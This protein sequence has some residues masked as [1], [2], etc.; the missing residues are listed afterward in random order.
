MECVVKK[1]ERGGA[2]YPCPECGK[3][4][5]VVITRRREGKVFRHRKCLECEEVFDTVEDVV[6]P[7]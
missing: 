3:V 4:T 5:H 6:E 7:A 2:S 1:R